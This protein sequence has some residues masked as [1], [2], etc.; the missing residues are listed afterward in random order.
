[1]AITSKELGEKLWNIAKKQR[2]TLSANDYKNYILGFIFYKEISDQFES[3]AN[4]ELIDENL[5]YAQL[6]E[7]EHQSFIDAI[8]NLSLQ[9]LGYFIFPFNLYN[10][11]LIKDKDEKF[12]FILEKVK[13]ALKSLEKSTLGENSQKVFTNIFEKI[14]LNNSNLGENVEDKNKLI[15]QTMLEFVDI[16]FTESEGDV[17]GDAYEYLISKFAENAGQKGGEFFTPQVVS[18][19]I[20]KLVTSNNEKIKKIYD[21]TCGSGSLLLRFRRELDYTPEFYGQEL[22]GETFNLARM[23]MVIHKIPYNKF[24]IQR[25]NTLENPKH[26][27]ELFDTIIANPPYS[28]GWFRDLLSLQD[29]RF[30]QYGVLAPK[31]KA[32]F[33]FVQHMVHHLSDNGTMAV[34]L[35][36][37][38]LFRGGPE[39]EIRKFLIK[40]KNYIDT[41]IGLPGNM[42]YGTGIATCIIILKKCRKSNDNILFIDASQEYDQV[43]NKNTINNKHIEKIVKA[44]IERKEI[45]KYAFPASLKM[46]E[47]NDYNLNISRYV[48][49]MEDEVKIDLNEVSN[50]LK[51]LNTKLNINKIEIN[52]FCNELGI[53][54]PFSLNDKE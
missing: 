27:G 6:N 30:S 45:F 38:I 32:D 51:T 35:P 52:N 9:K 43:G 50:K 53:E 46:I 22:N 54:F 39:A 11:L 24:N 16:N 47:D 31:T 21:P 29:E 40:N 5:N 2:G 25:G 19:L 7:K 23:N 42:F 17:L 36:H 20:V 8:K 13:N 26:L 14:D 48:N 41:I 12:P 4:K 18:K 1:M 37:G 34:V 44:F 3:F 33:A 15:Y 10:Q 28:I 49:T